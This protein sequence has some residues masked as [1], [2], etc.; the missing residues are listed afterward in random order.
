MERRREPRAT[1]DQTV[2]VTVL[3]RQAL[4]ISGTA[5]DISRRGLRLLLSGRVSP[6]DPVKIDMDDDLLLGEICYCETQGA[7]FIVGVELD[8]ALAGL[9]EL[10]RLNLALFEEP[11]SHRQ[12]AEIKLPSRPRQEADTVKNGSFTPRP[13]PSEP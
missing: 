3:G 2:V 11:I 7:D 6:G 8:Q 5:V 1:A 13:L 4:Q 10:A 12:V 9:S